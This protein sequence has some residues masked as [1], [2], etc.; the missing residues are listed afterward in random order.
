[1]SSAGA[2]GG[3]SSATRHTLSNGM[4]ALIQRNSSNQTVSIRGEVR[5]GSIH[6]SAEQSGLA[7]FTGATLIRGTQTRTFQQ[8]VQ[9]TESRGCSVQAGGGTHVSPFHGKALSED[10]GLVL[11][12]LGDILLRPTFPEQEIE[13]FR[14]QF[15]MSL[16]E[17]EQE[18]GTQVRRA[19]R[20]MLFP[21]DHPYSRLPMGTME[22]VQQITRDDLIGFYQRYHPGATTIAIVGDVD[23][24]AVIAELERVFGEWR[25]DAPLPSHDLPPVPA[26]E[27]IQKRVIPMPGKVRTDIG[28]AVHGMTRDNPEFY[29]AVVG[30]MVLGRLGMG[31]RLGENIRENQGLAY[32]TFSG[33]QA[34]FGAGPWMAGAGVNPANVERATEAMLDEIKQ[35]AQEGPTNEELADAKA[36]LTGSLVLGLERNSGV[37]AALLDIESYHLGLD[38]VERYPHLINAVTRDEIIDV[39]RAYLST[40][41]Y[42]LASAGP[43]SA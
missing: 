28:W 27:G 5:V 37:A 40:D 41:R 20:S 1:M 33:F 3:I 18:T 7:V 9:E 6:E 17:D 13:R 36:Y 29:T 26:L 19:I 32:H 21:P 35:F 42:V 38:Y 16:R 34:G 25:S 12:L 22:T 43:E 15:L 10:L 4:V 11:D 23:P 8:I 39:A 2:A 31:G 30:N 24:P 14:G